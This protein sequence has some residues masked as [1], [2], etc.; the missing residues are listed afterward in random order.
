MRRMNDAQFPYDV[1]LCGCWNIIMH[2][3]EIPSG[4]PRVTVAALVEHEGRFLFVEER[5]DQGR[6]VINQ[7]AGHV[8]AG[9][10]LLE[11]LL[12]ETFEETGWRVEPEFLVGAYLWGRAD[13]SI[14]YLRIAIAARP[15]RQDASAALDAGIERPVWLSRDELL[16]RRAEH[17][18]ALV[19]RCVD[20]Y[21]AGES[22]PL[23]VLKSLLG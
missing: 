19:L 20:D 6:L 13:L 17:R 7:P 22:Y 1:A 15:E 16:A 10:S 12:R 18:S 5:D 14:S 21:L 8:E 11:A 23:T 4:R 3:S 9:E 2:A